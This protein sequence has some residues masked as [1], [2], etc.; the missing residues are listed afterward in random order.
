M[1]FDG[2]EIDGLLN[3]AVA[4]GTFDGV[5]A[6]VV[7]RDGVLYEG[8][9]GDAGPDTMFRNASMTKAV[10]TTGALQLVEQDR[11]SLDQ[12][13]E[14]VLPEFGELQ[15]LEGFDG[16]RPVLRP[17]AGKATIRQLMTHTAGLGYFFIN[18]RLF[19]YGPRTGLPNP[20]EGQKVSLTAPLIADPAT[21][22]EYGVNVDWL[23][24]VLERLTGQTLG[25]YLAEHVYGPLGMTDSTFHPSDEQRARLLP[26]RMRA[27]DGTLKPTALDLPPEPEWDSGGHGSYGTARDYARFMRAWLNGGELDGQRIL[28]PST[29]TMA[30][31]DQIE[32]IPLPELTHSCVPELSNDVPALPVRQGF[33][34]GFHLVQEDVPGMRSAGT[35]DWSG[36]FN[37]YYWIDRAA[38]VGAVIMTQVLPFYDTKVLE[39]VLG[40]ELGV[41]SQVGAAVPAAV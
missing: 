28:E 17:P 18:E 23:G 22:W 34:L 19:E 36:I 38:G 21:I 15:V 13:V 1:G 2:S 8:A 32:G 40:F 5:V 30:F 31:E 39:T 11:L 25:A 16:D 12:T 24:L 14:S 6:M 35:G 10:A 9:A 41:Y 37:T 3:G 20:L 33:G 4:G 27:A 7:D 26:V 29:V